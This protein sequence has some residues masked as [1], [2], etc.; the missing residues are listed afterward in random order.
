VGFP[1]YSAPSQAAFESRV[2]RATFA[3]RTGCA[4]PCRFLS[5]SFRPR[6]ACGIVAPGPKPLECTPCLLFYS[7][8]CLCKPFIFNFLHSPGFCNALHWPDCSF[9]LLSSDFL[10]WPP[11][12]PPP[13]PPPPPPSPSPPPP[14]PPP[15]APPPTHL[16]PHHSSRHPVRFFRI[17]PAFH[18]LFMPASSFPRFFFVRFSLL[19]LHREHFCLRCFFGTFFPAPF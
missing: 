12:L 6:T 15:P 19:S 2:P 17:I 11:R 1:S 8:H 3:A 4:K 5:T 9:F 14:P 7:L 16:P 10:S 18:F 13:P